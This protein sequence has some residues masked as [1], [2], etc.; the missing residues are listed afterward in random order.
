MA[1]DDCIFCKIARGEIPARKV[2]EDAD[3][4]AFHDLHPQAPVHVLLIPKRH[5]AALSDVGPADADWLGR[6]LA[7]TPRL[8]QDLGVAQTGFRTIINSG[9]GVG[10]SVFHLHLHILAGR[11]MA[12]PP[13]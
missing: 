10:Q 13:G 7:L 2:Y 9:R 5:V 11:E 4:L 12:W 6:L 3:A 8:A 1:T